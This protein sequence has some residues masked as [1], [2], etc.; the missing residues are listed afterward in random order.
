MKNEQN[1][2][3]VVK[4][5]FMAFGN[6]TSY[7]VPLPIE[8]IYDNIY[9]E[10]KYV[11]F[12]EGNTFP[13]KLLE[14]IEST[15]I[16]ETIIDKITKFVIGQ[17]LIVTGQDMESEINTKG[18]TWNDLIK[19][20]VNDYI[21]FGAFSVQVRRNKVGDIKYLDYIPVERIRT[22]EENTKFWYKKHWTRYGTSQ[23]VYDA[24][25]GKREQ[26]NSIFYFKSNMRHVYG[27]GYWWSSID[28]LAILSAISDFDLSHVN[29]N[30][31][32]SAVVSFVEG[33]PTEA[34]QEEVEKKVNKKFSGAKNASKAIFT[35][36]D[37]AEGAPKITLLTPADMT[38]QYNALLERV[39][40]NVFAAFAIDPILLGLKTTDGV[41]STEQYDEIYNLFNKSHIEPMQREF[42]RAFKK[43]GYELTINALEDN[44]ASGE[45]NT[46]N[47]IVTEQ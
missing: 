22:N 30:F 11:P 7:D 3:K 40:E 37:N 25:N 47:N 32:P 28:D 8:K 27:R 10:D 4:N 31:A 24:F 15:S 16:V 13:E 29:N 9:N 20:L 36:S 19:H 21:S 38:A 12:G 1:S 14:M 26:S 6:E 33:V 2:D 45:N 18:M 35:F 34:E 42:I 5:Y 41:F 39:R 23:V 46:E 43:L 17:G 44:A